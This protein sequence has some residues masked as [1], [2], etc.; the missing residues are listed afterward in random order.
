MAVTLDKI[1][2]NHDLP[3]NCMA[4]LY[5]NKG[6][7]KSMDNKLYA[8]IKINIHFTNKN[9]IKV[10][11][12]GTIKFR[13]Q[14]YVTDRFIIMQASNEKN[15]GYRE[16]KREKIIKN[17]RDNVPTSLS[18]ILTSKQPILYYKFEKMDDL[19]WKI[20]DLQRTILIC[21]S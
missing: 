3:L 16:I 20:S 15:S 9:E 17:E 21:R 4:M 13:N 5:I 7:N 8:E 1:K 11:E 18:D 2:T 19:V 6:E 14:E 10:S 12:Y